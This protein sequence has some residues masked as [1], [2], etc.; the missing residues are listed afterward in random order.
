[1]AGLID[2]SLAQIARIP[3]MAV[4]AIALLV[5]PVA[6]QAQTHQPYA[7]LETRSIK[8]LSAEEIAD[9]RVGRGM[10]LALAAE[11]NGYPGPVHVLE[12]ASPLGLSDAQQARV[13]QLFE[14][15]KAEA[16]PLGEQ[17]IAAE[18]ALD[19][20]FASRSV[21]QPSLAQG[22]QEIAAAQA[23]LRA[24]HLKYHLA[25]VELLTPEQVARYGE[26]RGYASAPHRHR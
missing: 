24:A 25:M 18:A 10:G 11:L 26:L 20:Q 6:G 5:A 17:L 14:A 19:R 16:M 23:A 7:G 15:M 8:A 2:G 12:L 4:P 13:R 22:V 1:M 3:A 21:T 9:L